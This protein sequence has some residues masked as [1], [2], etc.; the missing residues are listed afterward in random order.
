M[1]K[2]FYRPMPN[3]WL[4]CNNLNTS[5][6]TEA[7][8]ETRMKYKYFI[9]VYDIASFPPIYKLS[10]YIRRREAAEALF[11]C[12]RRHCRRKYFGERSRGRNYNLAPVKLS[13]FRMPP[14]RVLWSEDDF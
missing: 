12:P 10:V 7:I 14:K 2:D 6:M 8:A 13:D 1:V 5:S 4:E 3:P 9:Q 11:D